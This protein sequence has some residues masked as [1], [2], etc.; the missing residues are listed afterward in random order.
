MSNIYVLSAYGIVGLVMMGWVVLLS[1]WR[2]H[3]NRHANK[4]SV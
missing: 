2:K 4:R 3:R 1:L